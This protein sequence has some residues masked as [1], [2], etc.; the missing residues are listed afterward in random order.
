MKWGDEM[1]VKVVFEEG[2]EVRTLRGEIVDDNDDI[3][4]TIKEEGTG[5]VFKINKNCISKIIMNNFAGK[6]G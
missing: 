3:F 2:D 4:L 1:P 6:E 5:K